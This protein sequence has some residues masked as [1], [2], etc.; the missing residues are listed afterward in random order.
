MQSILFLMIGSSSYWTWRLQQRL[1]ST[2]PRTPTFSE[3]LRVIAAWVLLGLVPLVIFVLTG[4]VRKSQVDPNRFVQQ[5]N[6]SLV[7]FYVAY[8]DKVSILGIFIYYISRK[9]LTPSLYLVGT[10]APCAA[11]G[12]TVVQK[13][14]SI[15]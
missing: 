14:K 10:A 8:S 5:L 4:M 2:S 1:V 15:E 9:I 7:Q 12:R 11:A 3:N 13:S 6:R